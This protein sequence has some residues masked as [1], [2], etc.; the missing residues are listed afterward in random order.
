[1][2]ALR[3]VNRK[4]AEIRHKFENE[5]FEDEEEWEMEEEDNEADQADENEN[6]EAG[7]NIKASPGKKTNVDEGNYGIVLSF[8]DLLANSKVHLA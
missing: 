6:S 3:E 7:E 2:K 1:M 5:E 4:E 8:I